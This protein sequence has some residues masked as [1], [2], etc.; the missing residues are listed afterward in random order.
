LPIFNVK[1][2]INFGEAIF[3]A[4]GT[5]K[6]E[7][8]R[9]VELLIKSDLVGHASHGIL[10]LPS[11]INRILDGSCKPGNNIKIVKEHGATALVDGD[12]GLGQ[13]VATKTMNIVLEKAEK[14][15]VGTVATFNCFHIGRMADYALMAS[16]QDMIGFCAVV[17]RPGVAPFGGRERIFNQSPIGIA[18]PAGKEDDFMLDISSSVCAGGKIMVAMAKGEK[19]PEGYI[20]DKK[21]NP[22][23]DPKDFFDGGAVLPFGGPVGYKGY[24]L[25]MAVD[26]IAGLLSGRGSAFDLKN[27]NQGIFQMAIKIDVFQPIKEFKDNMDKLITKV[28]NSRKAP[29][30]KEIFIPG[31]IEKKKEKETMKKGITIPQKTWERIIDTAKKVNLNIEEFF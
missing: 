14:Y 6:N 23:T 18:V 1:Q 4:V 30:V 26:I 25:A 29:G 27:K 17:E 21:G 28:K 12:W 8:K 16:N 9:T 15:G 5:P 7:A 19:L 11:Y 10:R 3:M 22:S 31:E 24:G 2:L 20:I 13:V